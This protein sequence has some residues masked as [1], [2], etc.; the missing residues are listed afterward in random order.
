MTKT[1]TMKPE[2]FRKTWKRLREALGAV[3][4]GQNTVV[5]QLLVAFFAGGHILLEGVPGLG[6]NRRRVERPRA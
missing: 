3:I 1:A 4:V 5:E 2:E 6:K